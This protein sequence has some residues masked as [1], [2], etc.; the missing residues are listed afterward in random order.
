MGR[1]A[2][3]C[4]GAGRA[5]WAIILCPAE[6]TGAAEFL[7]AVTD[8]GPLGVTVATCGAVPRCGRIAIASTNANTAAVAIPAANQLHAGRERCRR[9]S[10]SRAMVRFSSP[11]RGSLAQPASALSNSSSILRS[12]GLSTATLH[13]A[14]QLFPQRLPGAKDARSHRRLRYAQHLRRFWRC[15]FFDC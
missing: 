1:L 14:A 4:T 15:K 7:F 13:Y 10:R 11:A 8:T 6:S 9:A 12:C 5:A 3:R 2:A